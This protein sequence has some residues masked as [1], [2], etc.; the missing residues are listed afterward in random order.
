VEFGLDIR[1]SD[2]RPESS[3]ANVKSAALVEQVVKAR[4]VPLKDKR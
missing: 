1:V 2:A 3:A 4:F